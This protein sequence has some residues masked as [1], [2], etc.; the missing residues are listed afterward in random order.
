MALFLPFEAAYF[1]PAALD[2]YILGSM[3]E[4][5][6][7][8]GTSPCDDRIVAK[9]PVTK[10]CIPEIAYYCNKYA[11]VYAHQSSTIASL[12][13]MDICWEK[14]QTDVKTAEKHHDKAHKHEP[15]F[16]LQLVACMQVM[17]HWE[18]KKETCGANPPLVHC[19]AD[20]GGSG[21]EKEETGERKVIEADE[22][23]P[24]GHVVKV[25]VW[26]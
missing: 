11:D 21:I 19:I 17:D 8:L 6:I 3:P 9:D 14:Y 2:A 25:K 26:R 15:P 5:A 16:L 7:L 23:V 10:M 12:R 22:E 1:L 20:Y 24:A 4:L 13:I 18:K